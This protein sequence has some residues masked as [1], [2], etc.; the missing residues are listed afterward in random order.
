MLLSALAA[1]LYFVIGARLL[2]GYPPLIV[3]AAAATLGAATLTVVAVVASGENQWTWPAVA[4][5]VALGVGP[6]LLSNLWW[7]ETVEWLD[8][9][10]AALTVY[11]I[12]L[13]TMVFAVALLGETI[14]PAQLAGAALLLSGVWL[15]E[16]GQTP[17]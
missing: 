17:V 13:I 9:G 12:P 4:A 8:A 15:A 7:W 16:R 6:G 1:A 11:L 14:S 3:T 10:R 2:R 5:I